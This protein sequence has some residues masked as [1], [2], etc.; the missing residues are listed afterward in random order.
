MY[1]VTG[2]L[3][4]SGSY[5][6]RAI[7]KRRLILP[8]PAAAGYLVTRLI[9]ALKRDIFLTRHEVAALM[10]N[11]LCTDGPPLGTTKLSEWT[12]QHAPSLG[13]AYARSGSRRARS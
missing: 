6:A 7:G 3:S 8:V 1:C 2:A 4:Y 5:V 12:A 13:Q 11:L 10:G 9:G